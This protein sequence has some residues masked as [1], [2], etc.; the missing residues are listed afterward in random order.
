MS[1]LSEFLNGMT[2]RQKFTLGIGAVVVASTLFVFVRMIRKPE[3][4]TL[5]SGMNA[6]DSQALGSKLAAK[7]I[8]YQVSPD[9]SSVS[10]PSDSLD[11][12]RLE[13][14]SDGVPKSGRLGFEIFDQTNWGGTDF[15]EKVNYQRAM[16]GELERTI[17]SLSDV[18]A[19]RVHLVLPGEALFV[20]DK[21]EPKASV[22]V[23]LRGQRYTEETH[24]AISRLVAA[25]VD[26]LR[27][28]NVTVVDA[29]TNRPFNQATGADGS[30]ASL[31]QRL[32]EK[33]V[34][35][36]EPV[37]GAQRV[38]ASVRVEYDPTS[39]EE[40]QETYDPNSTV[41]LSMQKTEERAG[42]GTSVSGVPGTAAN[43]PGS[44]AAQSVTSSTD[45]SLRSSRSENGTYAVNRVVRHTIVP[46]GRVRR[47]AAALLV[48]DAME[49]KDQNGQRTQ[50]RR[51]RSPEEMKQFE[52][53]AKA[54]IGIDATRGDVLA[55]ENLSF[56]M[57]PV[58]TPAS[59]GKAERIR[60]FTNEWSGV[61]R[62]VGVG[63]LFVAVY[64]LFLR[65]IKKQAVDAFK[66]IGHTSKGKIVA[67]AAAG[68]L[69]GPAQ[70]HPSALFTDQTPESS[71]SAALKRHLLDKVKS[72]PASAS[73]LVQSWVR[74]GSE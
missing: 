48:D 68:D 7:K 33:L 70:I 53:L 19:V 28:E 42:G 3:Y 47:V 46:A 24:Q 16:E 30:T 44:Q 67:G 56:E 34:R 63:L 36:L 27:P 12:A 60:T 45:D 13:L 54:A 52:E 5:Y 69:V 57:L 35:T 65:P 11:S 9:G 23:K 29:D 73:R 18:E 14:A 55:V 61:L 37:V 8:D 72:E 21:R 26:K 51:K 40:N 49:W 41:T 64:F 50:S 62:N 2:T 10:V 4:K 32:S 38:R 59:A 31:E 22:I 17:Q 71:R 58:E 39:A 25:A 1:Q 6:S 20:E 43:V 66:Q 15:T 74:E